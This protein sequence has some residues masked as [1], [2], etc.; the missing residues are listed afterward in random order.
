MLESLQERLIRCFNKEF[1]FKVPGL[2]HTVSPYIHPWRY[3]AYMRYNQT[4]SYN[5]FNEVSMSIGMDSF[6]ISQD[7][8][9]GICSEIYYFG[10]NKLVK[11][12]FYK[13]EVNEESLT[14]LEMEVMFGNPEFSWYE[15]PALCTAEDYVLAGIKAIRDELN[16][17]N[18]VMY[19]YYENGKEM[20]NEE[21]L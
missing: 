17:G 4:K 8:I 13:K 2:E 12:I 16:K 7:A 15:R 9:T 6:F 21:L 10:F 20:S 3:A 19:I 11:S 18:K 5:A 1:K 14:A